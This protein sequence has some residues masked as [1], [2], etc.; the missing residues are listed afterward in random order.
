VIAQAIHA[1]AGEDYR[2]A[3][4]PLLREDIRRIMATGKIVDVNVV[5]EPVPGGIRLIYHVWEKPILVGLQFEGNDEIDDKRLRRE[6]GWDKSSRVFVD[7]D[8]ME[9]YKQKLLSLYEDRSFPRT[10]ISVEEEPQATPFESVLIFQIKEGKQLP[11][12]RLDILGNNEYSDREIRKRMQT[13]KSWWFFKRDY[14]EATMKQ[15]LETIRN[16][17]LDRGYLDVEVTKEGPYEE[18]KGLGVSVKIA[19][20]PRYRLGDVSV[21]GNEIFTDEEILDE[22]SLNK[23]DF[24]SEGTVQL[25]LL[26]V[27][28]MHRSQGNYFTRIRKNLNKREDAYIVDVEVTIQESERLHLGEIEI[29]GV[30]RME[31][32]NELILLEEDEFVTKDFVILREIKLESGEVLDWSKVIEADRRL[33]NLNYFKSRPYPRPDV[34]NLDPGFSEPLP[35][36]DDPTVADL[37]LQLEEVRTGLIT[38]GGSYNT[39][40]GP[41]AFVEYS[42]RNLFGRGQEVR[43]LVEFGGLRDRFS[44]EFLEPYLFGSEYAFRSTAYYYDIDSYG[45]REFTEERYGLETILSHPLWEHS[46]YSIGLKAEEA[47][48]EIFDERRTD[49]VSAPEIYDSGRNT[50]TSVTFGLSRDTR[51]FRANPTSGTFSR[52]SLELAG[53]AD[54]EFAKLI[55]E[56]NWYH[57]LTEKLVLALSGETRLAE[58]FGGDDYLP[59]QE[60][61]WIGG[62]NTVRGFESG[63]L[64]ERDTV[65]RRYFYSELGLIERSREIWLGSEAALIGKAELRYPFFDI[66]QG[67]A[68]VDSGA[69]YSEIGEIDPSELRF[70]TGVGV[71]VDLPIGAMIRL[72]YAVP[73][74]LEDE[75]EEENFHFSFGQSF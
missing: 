66:L 10:T 75:D 7:E 37:L 20:G 58:P 55:A 6:L 45:G 22:F 9:S 11:L 47:D 70:S 48:I 50:T 43:T 51:D 62:A 72:D 33:V 46:R 34:L 12:R 17:Y 14:V 63:T 25:D 65:I 40:F 60:R 61:F 38:F 57:S 30:T 35:R 2:A 3:L 64:S 42:K 53:L 4:R 5:R 26:D 73:I 71:R 41:G 59:L 21:K 28:N 15:D 31:G 16:M 8:L 24:Y 18:G 52:A 69:G 32:T 27:L 54:N 68:F 36:T 1:K 74:K 44:V 67:V 13:K 23:G 19:E 39:T 49:V 56:T 29:Q